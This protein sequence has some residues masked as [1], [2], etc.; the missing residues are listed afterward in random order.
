MVFGGFWSWFAWFD[1][2]NLS[3]IVFGFAARWLFE[4]LLGQ[5]KPPWCSLLG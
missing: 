5:F 4:V 2:L 3:E 1:F